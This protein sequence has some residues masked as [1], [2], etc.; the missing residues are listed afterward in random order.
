MNRAGKVEAGALLVDL[1]LEALRGQQGRLHRI[2]QNLFAALGH[3]PVHRLVLEAA[4][5]KN[6][7]GFRARCLLALSVIQEV[8]DVGDHLLLFGLLA[9]PNLGVRRAAASAIDRT[10]RAR[11]DSPKVLPDTADLARPLRP[12]CKPAS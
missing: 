8:P 11:P 2:T 1:M 4:N 6:S 12:D 10:R 9:D 3:G 5:R 7:P